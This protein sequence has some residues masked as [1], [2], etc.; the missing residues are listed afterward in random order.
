MADAQL[1]AVYRHDTHKMLNESHDDGTFTI[2]GVD[3][4]AKAPYGADSDAAAMSRPPGKRTNGSNGSKHIRRSLITGREVAVGSDISPA[5][6]RGR[7]AEFVAGEDAEAMHADW[8]SADL[9]AFFN[10][11][12]IYPY[13]SLRYH[14]LL[15]AALTAAYR[16][17]ADYGDLHLV[18]TDRVIPHHTVYDGRFRLS[19]LA[20]PG[21]RPSARLGSRPWR[22]WHGVW[23]RLSEHP[24]DTAADRFDM[25]L[26]ATLRRIQAWS[27]AL[28]FIE[29]YAKY[30]DGLCDDHNR[31]TASGEA[32]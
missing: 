8:L 23:N 26:D 32:Q 19:I 6:V 3:V 27:T 1:L 29:D 28:Q 25:Q 14:T 10:E 13:T 9:P 21:D 24:L 11:W 30:R 12:E 20:D 2:G 16:D 7:V 18:V 17:G 22:N 15:V 5:G 4:G 31:P